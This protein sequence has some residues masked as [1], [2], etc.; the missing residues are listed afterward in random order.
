MRGISADAAATRWRGSWKS[1]GIQTAVG[2]ETRCPARKD[3]EGCSTLTPSSHGSCGDTAREPGGAGQEALAGVT[4][5]LKG[6]Q[7]WRLRSS[8]CRT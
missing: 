8:G 2:F 6:T 7:R 3:P 5:C 4:L 1:P